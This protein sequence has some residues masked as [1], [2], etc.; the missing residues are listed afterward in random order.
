M[1][2]IHMPMYVYDGSVNLFCSVDCV[3]PLLS[4]FVLFFFFFIFQVFSSSLPV[5]LTDC[6]I[7]LH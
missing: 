1:M 6:D 2:M 4:L 3:H 7:E 5:P